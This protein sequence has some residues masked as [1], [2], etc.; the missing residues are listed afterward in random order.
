MRMDIAIEAAKQTRN[1]L[2][3]IGD[4]PEHAALEALAD[5][6]EYITFLLRYNGIGE[7]VEHIVASR[8]F[9]FPSIEPFGIAPVESLAAGTPVIGLRK[10][11]ALDI[12][13]PGVNGVFFEEQTVE[14]VAAAMETFAGMDFDR[15]KVMESAMKFSEAE[16]VRKLEKIVQENLKT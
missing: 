15:K 12:I 13:E 4:G 5:R 2:L 3:V 11:G 8:A 9:I 6:S 16:F 1:Q 10:G 7:I 14:S